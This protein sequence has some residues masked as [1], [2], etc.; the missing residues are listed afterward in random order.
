MTAC[1]HTDEG[2]EDFPCNLPKGHEGGHSTTL[3]V[4]YGDL[5]TPEER[6]HAEE[7][8]RCLADPPYDPV[9]DDVRR[10]LAALDRLAPKEK[11]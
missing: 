7:V 10:L 9:P 11:G 5:L 2:W 4:I 6:D 3:T 1:M 8:R